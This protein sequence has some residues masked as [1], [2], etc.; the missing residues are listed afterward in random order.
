MPSS[1]S[2]YFSISTETFKYLPALTC[3]YKVTYIL[4]LWDLLAF[5]TLEALY[6]LALTV[7]HP[8]RSD[9]IFIL[10]S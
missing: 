4:I 3:F 7:C 8:V 9:Y 5:V 6:P 2:K 1:L 10:V